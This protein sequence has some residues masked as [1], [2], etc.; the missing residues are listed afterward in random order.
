MTKS[1]YTVFNKSLNKFIFETKILL[2]KYVQNSDPFKVNKIY[3]YN[4]K[5]YLEENRLPKN[6]NQ[7]KK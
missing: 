7:S 4:L 5:K 1:T 3:F 2:S 6:G